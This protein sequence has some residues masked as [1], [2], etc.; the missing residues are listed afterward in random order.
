MNA[1]EILVDLLSKDLE[2]LKMTLSDFSDADMLV[3]PTPAANHTTWQL[4]H[5]IAS[6]TS[7]VNS[8]KAGAMPEL[9]A[10][11]KEK[12]T[13]ETTKSDDAGAFPK[14]NELLAQ[15]EKTR[16]ATAKWARSLTEKD[17]AI[18]SPESM[19]QWVPTV[20][21]MQVIRRKLGKPILF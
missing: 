13:P 1:S 8:I 18:P 14:K 20:G 19:R 17:Y 21:H 16:A 11:F 10:G 3:R 4:G 12:F 2:M 15:F 7:M 9:P 5:L 6:E